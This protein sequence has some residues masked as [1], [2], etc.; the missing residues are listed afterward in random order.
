MII[1]GAGSSRDFSVS[2]PSEAVRKVST[3][4]RQHGTDA[5][6]LS[7]LQMWANASFRKPLRITLK[8]SAFVIDYRE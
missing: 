8:G 3:A 6:V 4:L 2:D 7:S 1:T 5:S